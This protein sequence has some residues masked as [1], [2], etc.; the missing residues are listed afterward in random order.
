MRHRLIG[1]PS[2]PSFRHDGCAI[3]IADLPGHIVFLVAGVENNDAVLR[4]GFY[5]AAF[6]EANRIAKLRLRHVAKKTQ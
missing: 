5:G 4:K 3:L 2:F 1:F 6:C